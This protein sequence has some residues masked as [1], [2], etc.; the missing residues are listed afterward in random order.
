MT[1]FSRLH[2]LAISIITTSNSPK[3]EEHSSTT[4]FHTIPYYKTHTLIEDVLV[5]ASLGSVCHDG[6]NHRVHPAHAVAPAQ[7]VVPLLSPF[8]APRVLDD[9]IRLVPEAQDGKPS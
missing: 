1:E 5:M 9:P 8:L 4:L 3:L 6:R 2:I 7:L